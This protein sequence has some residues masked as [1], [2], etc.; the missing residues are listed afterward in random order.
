MPADGR[1]QR[2]KKPKKAGR[3][4]GKPSAFDGGKLAALRDRKEMSQS[5]LAE[6]A[7]LSFQLISRYERG[8]AE[9]SFTTAVQLADALGAAL[10]EFRAEK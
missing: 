8:R 7:G 4:K 1:P 3:P 6:A 2:R 10:G 5:Q 9:P